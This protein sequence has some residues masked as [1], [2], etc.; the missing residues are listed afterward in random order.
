MVLL[1]L[2]RVAI[3]HTRVHKTNRLPSAVVLPIYIQLTCVA[4]HVDVF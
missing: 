4:F 2:R 3:G 1:I